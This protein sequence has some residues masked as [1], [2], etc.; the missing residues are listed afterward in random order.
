MIRGRHHFVFGAETVLMQMDERNV[1]LANGE[2]TFS[3]QLTN[4]ALADF[5][6]GRPSRLVNGN[7]FLVD[8]RQRYI[9]RTQLQVAALQLY[10][11][12]LR[13]LLQLHI[14]RFGRDRDRPHHVYSR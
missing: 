9:M 2:W 3:G 8:L 13:E 7:Y 6:I 14:L 10:L 5:M 12:R 1:S 11:Q 4:D